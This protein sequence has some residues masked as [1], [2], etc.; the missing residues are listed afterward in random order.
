MAC[1][2]DFTVRHGATKPGYA[3]GMAKGLMQNLRRF[4]LGVIE[5]ARVPAAAHRDSSW[6]FF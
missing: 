1:T 3:D 4:G 2:L 5:A 6:K